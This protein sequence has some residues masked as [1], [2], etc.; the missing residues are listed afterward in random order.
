MNVFKAIF[1]S[2]L[3]YC[4]NIWASTY[5]NRIAKLQKLQNKAI[6]IC[7]NLKQTDHIDYNKKILIIKSITIYQFVIYMYKRKHN[8]LHSTLADIF[9]LNTNNNSRNLRSVNN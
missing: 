8:L 6:R 9:N 5:N 1:Q 7:L 3:N 2:K 4:N